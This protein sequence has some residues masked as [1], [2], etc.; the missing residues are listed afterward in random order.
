VNLDAEDLKNFNTSSK[1]IIDSENDKLN[2][3]KLF[4]TEDDNAVYDQFEAEK[5]A[6]IEGDLK[7]RM[8]A[9]EVKRGWN[10]WA[11]AGEGINENRHKQ[12]QA[13]AEE[14]RKNKIEE[15][16]KKRAD[17]KMK[18]VVLNTEERDKKFALKYLVKELPHPYKNVD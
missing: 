15:M 10:E 8:P 7:D 5:Q 6:E 9:I 3:K 12:K 2:M 4:V 16:K 1:K 14:I 11:G 17:N 13:K 18:G